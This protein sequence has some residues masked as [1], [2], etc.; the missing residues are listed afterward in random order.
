MKRYRGGV[1]LVEAT[2]A[3]A[4]ASLAVGTMVCLADAGSRG[5]T[6]TVESVDAL[7]S[8]LLAV[9]ALRRDT[10][11]MV[12]QQNGDLAILD[13]GTGFSFLVPEQSSS[14]DPWSFKTVAIT[15]TLVPAGK[16]GAY[17]LV[18]R[19]P[20]GSAPVRGSWLTDL[21]VRYCA[22]GALGSV[23]PYLS[24]SLTA[25]G[26]PEARSRRTLSF[27]VP[28]DVPPSSTNA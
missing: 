18:R 15:W 5:T 24:I 2:F 20:A 11:R 14:T 7:R 17:Q 21:S 13:G 4:L 28:L 8:G 1:T 25:T 26:S 23:R 27:I 6:K 10:G 22:P 12:V 16:K 9:E 3:L 19:G